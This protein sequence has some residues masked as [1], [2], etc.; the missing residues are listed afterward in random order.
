MALAEEA[1]RSLLLLIREALQNAVRHASPTE[2]SV[3]IVYGGGDLSLEIRD[4]GCGFDPAAAAPDGHHY[5]L[6]GMRERVAVF[7]GELAVDSA[8][9][10]G[11]S[12]RLRVPLDSLGSRRRRVIGYLRSFSAWSCHAAT[13]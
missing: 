10:H 6:L 11:T 13:F 5:G 8:P 3:G 12:V 4:N 1:A 2:L 7:G 9:G